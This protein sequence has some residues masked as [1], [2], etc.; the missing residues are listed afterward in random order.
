MDF[1]YA[2]KRYDPV[3][4]VLRKC[5]IFVMTLGFSRRMFCQPFVHE[6]LLVGSEVGHGEVQV[7]DSRGRLQQIREAVGHRQPPAFQKRVAEHEN[8]YFGFASVFRVAG[9]GIFGGA[10]L[11]GLL[12]VSG[13]L[14]LP[15]VG[16]MG[17]V[18]YG[19]TRLGWRMRSAW[20]ERRLRQVIERVSSI[21][22]DVATLPPG[23]LGDD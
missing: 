5:W 23:E 9:G 8:A 22:Q 14:S 1:G 16:M 2:G 17:A 18:S 4:G 12:G 3:R 7:R 10:T 20:W 13:P 6:K 19:A 11:V 21:A 15:L